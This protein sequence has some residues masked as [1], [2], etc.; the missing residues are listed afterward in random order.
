MRAG[1]IEPYKCNKELR[2]NCMQL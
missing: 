1:Q 2:H